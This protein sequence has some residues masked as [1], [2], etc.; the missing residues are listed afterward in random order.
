M[1]IRFDIY[2]CLDNEVAIDVATKPP[3]DGYER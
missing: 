3:D 1:P 2:S